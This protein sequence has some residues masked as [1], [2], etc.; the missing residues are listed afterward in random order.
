MLIIAT[1]Q[2][3]LERVH[4]RRNVEAVTD[5]IHDVLWMFGGPW[6]RRW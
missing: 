1:V 4:E 6:Y 5:L 2:F 3:E